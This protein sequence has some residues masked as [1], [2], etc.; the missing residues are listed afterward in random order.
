MYP[1]GNISFN[2]LVKQGWAQLLKN[3]IAFQSVSSFQKVVKIVL[4]LVV[5]KTHYLE[6]VICQL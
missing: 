3:N 6:A 4:V 2:T 5:Q 1:A